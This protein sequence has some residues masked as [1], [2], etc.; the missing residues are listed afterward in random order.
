MLRTIAS[1]AEDLHSVPSTHRA[2]P[3]CTSSSGGSD[4]GTVTSR[5]THI[6]KIN[7]FPS[8]VVHA[9]NP[10]VPAP[11]PE[12]G[13]GESLSSRLARATHRNPVEEGTFFKVRGRGAVHS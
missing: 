1:T 13:T 10:L 9:F 3:N 5:H 8:N 7:L 12:S 11:T 2:A 6:H 4:S